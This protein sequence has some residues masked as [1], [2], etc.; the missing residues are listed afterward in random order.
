MCSSSQGCLCQRNNCSL[1]P[2]PLHPAHYP[3]SD[4]SEHQLLYKKAHETLQQD[5]IKSPVYKEEGFCPSHHYQK[6]D[7]NF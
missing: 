7:T 3:V 6:I 5:I 2:T 4:R 1:P